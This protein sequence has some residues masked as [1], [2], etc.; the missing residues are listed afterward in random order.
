MDTATVGAVLDGPNT[1]TLAALTATGAGAGAGA[2]ARA[3]LTG[4]AG[5]ALA[6]AL[7]PP[8]LC[9]SCS[10]PPKSC[11][12]GSPIAP[13]IFAAGS[14]ARRAAPPSW[15]LPRA[16][17]R[18]G[19][20]S[21]KSTGGAP[22]GRNM[23]AVSSCNLELPNIQSKISVLLP[24]SV[25]FSSVSSRSPHAHSTSSRFETRALDPR[26][27]RGSTVCVTVRVRERCR[28]E[29]RE[30]ARRPRPA[31]VEVS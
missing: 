23:L 22:N 29:V 18:M 27:P 15:A 26:P 16:T 5:G 2:G 1:L 17:P 12:D 8:P 4:G 21:R 31:T 25:Q 11:A 3:A 6:G 20:A 7:P 14:G 13:G 19:A 9:C 10:K 24:V 30:D 28:R